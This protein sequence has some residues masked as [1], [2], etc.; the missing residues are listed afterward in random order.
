M[1]NVPFE[2]RP[3]LERT[4]E[5]MAAF[6]GFDAAMDEFLASWNPDEQPVASISDSRPRSSSM[7]A[8]GLPVLDV[9][10]R[11]RQLA[12]DDDE[13]AVWKIVT[14]DLAEPS[15]ADSTVDM[16]G[17]DSGTEA[18]KKRKRS[19]FQLLFLTYLMFFIGVKT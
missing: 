18:T 1:T 19:V 12:E 3:A 2:D 10:T 7:L 13:L 9:N 14:E 8:A 16:D 6:V 15:Q 17:S 4:A 11:L 5:G